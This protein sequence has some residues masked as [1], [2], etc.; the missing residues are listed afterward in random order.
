MPAP[1]LQPL[2]HPHP[3]HTGEASG[4][5]FH[6]S[7][8]GQHRAGLVPTAPHP[9][10]AVPGV[11]GGDSPSDSHAAKSPAPAHV[12]L[13]GMPLSGP[14]LP[15]EPPPERAPHSPRQSLVPIT[16]VRSGG[17]AGLS[18]SELAAPHPWGVG[19]GLAPLI[20]PPAASPSRPSA[21]VARR[22]GGASGSLRRTVPPARSGRGAGP[23]GAGPA[24]HGP[25]PPPCRA[26]AGRP[27]PP[28]PSLSGETW[29][30]RGEDQGW[31]ATRAGTGTAPRG[32]NG[33][34]LGSLHAQHWAER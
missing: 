17:R 5:L 6:R 7:H 12:P 32:R 14:F 26:R 10:A 29:S 24:R 1:F 11:T 15:T 28:R 25:H 21:P 19:V 30:S 2:N 3:I 27:A 23:E 4:V 20:L 8:S 13:P 31:A 22:L 33:A 18:C 9:Y 34:G 16:A